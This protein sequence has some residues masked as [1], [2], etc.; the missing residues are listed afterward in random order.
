[1]YK[2]YWGMEFNPFDKEISE[3]KFY[4]NQDFTEMTKRLEYLKNVRGIGLFTG[5]PGTGKTACCRAFVS[6][7]NPS[8][9]KVV[10]LPLTTISASE[11]YRDLA[12]GL[13]L[14]PCYR[15]IDNFRSIQERIRGLYCKQKTTLVVLID[16]AQ[17]LG[18]AILADLKLLMNFEMDSRNYAVLVLAG[19]PTLNNTLSMQ[20]HEALRQRIVI[21]Y[22]MQGLTAQ[23]GG[24][25]AKDRMRICG[26]SREVF[27]PAALEAASGCCGGSIRR[28]AMLLH[29]AL[30]IG[31]E[32]KRDIIG[33][34]TVMD[35]VNEI[36]LV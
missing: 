20:V 13:G 7:L 36:D 30:I 10:Y 6:G 25:Y 21:S 22:Q 12:K 9:Y 31:C 27:E 14:E 26:V 17:Y 4:K 16:E 29:R 35:A 15:K 34:E 23:E 8:L 1:M 33:T 19:Q 11:F 32:Q 18:R 2:A 5:L 28:L 24:D 3:K